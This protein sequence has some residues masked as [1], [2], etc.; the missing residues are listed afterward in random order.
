[1]V[2]HD[3]STAPL[4]AAQ[5]QKVA[6][7]RHTNVVR[8]LGWSS[9]QEMGSL[10]AVS[11]SSGTA[12]V[13][14]GS[15]NVAATISSRSNPGIT[16]SGT[17]VSMDATSSHSLDADIWELVAAARG[18]KRGRI[19]LPVKTH[20]RAASLEEQHDSGS[21]LVPLPGPAG[22]S[23]LGLAPQPSLAKVTDSP[24]TSDADI[25]IHEL[26]TAEDSTSLDVPAAD[27][28]AQQDAQPA[29][30]ADDVALVSSTQA[31]AAADTATDDG[32]VA[33]ACPAVTYQ[34]LGRVEGSYSS[35][36]GSSSYRRSMSGHVDC[37]ETWVLLEACD[38]GS[39]AD[40]LQKGRWVVQLVQL[41][42]ESCSMYAVDMMFHGSGLQA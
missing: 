15:G 2:E 28:K 41:V 36:G 12:R 42:R 4:L 40:A 9:P 35:A 14:R 39:L 18:P 5:L 8:T 23:P 10:Q 32:S 38:K 17:H 34:S 37:Q 31:D 24:R 3:E 21:L 1:V 22:S 6:G 11:G 7:L 25:S 27:H 33:S 16:L 19:P 29:G 26:S 30:A 13:S 20:M